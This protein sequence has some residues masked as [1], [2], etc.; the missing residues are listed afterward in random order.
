MPTP[1]IDIEVKDRNEV[2]LVLQ[3]Y[4]NASIIK[5]NKII[6]HNT[7]IYTCNVKHDLLNNLCTIDYKQMEE[8]PYN[9]PKIDLLNSNILGLFNNREEI[10]ELL[11]IEPD[12]NMFKDENIVSQLFQLSKHY[13]IIQQYLPDSIYK[14]AIILA[15][16]RPGKKYLIGQSWEDIEKEIWNK[17]NEGYYFKKSHAIAYAMIII[18]HLN[19]MRVLQ[20]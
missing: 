18:L 15:L 12:W 7:G 19:L 14:V 20:S 11:N 3:Q 13:N 17:P 9:I 1:D 16:I 4:H 6:K 2:L 10:I 5:N 8:Y